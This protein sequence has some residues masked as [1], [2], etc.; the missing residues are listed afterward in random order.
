MLTLTLLGSATA[1]TII[2]DQAGGGDTTTIAEALELALDGD[3]IEIGPG[4]YYEWD[5]R[6]P[7]DNL[8]IRGAGPDHTI[9]DTALSGSK[10]GEAIVLSTSVIVEGLGFRMDPASEYAYGLSYVNYSD[11]IDYIA[12]IENCRFEGLDEA[13]T[14][15]GVFDTLYIFDSVFQDV[16]IGIT[17]SDVFTSSLHI[18]SNLFTGIVIQPAILLEYLYGDPNT[19][20]HVIV[21][22]TF[23]G[24]HG[25]LARMGGSSSQADLVFEGNIVADGSYGV[26]LDRDRGDQVAYNLY[27]GLDEKFDEWKFTLAGDHDNIE[28][29][30]AFCAWTEGAALEDQDLR[31]RPDSPAIDHQQDTGPS[32]LSTDFDGAARPLDGDEDGTTWH[33]AGAWEYDPAD[34]CVE[35]TTPGDTAGPVDSGEIVDTGPPATDTAPPEDTA[36]GADTASSPADSGETLEPG[37]SPTEAGCGCRGGGRALLFLPLLAL[38]TR[39]RRRP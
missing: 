13:I 28:A 16:S 29:E 9:L 32:V 33:D 34:P 31:L 7:V 3:T 27:H 1:A 36:S 38:T 30:P 10:P 22:N 26:Y 5:L 15:R 24:N 23:V 6:A 11:T 4:V 37:G 8:T 17:S 21:H 18:E 19:A 20:H 39:R 14:S 25:A 2:V 35:P 12:V